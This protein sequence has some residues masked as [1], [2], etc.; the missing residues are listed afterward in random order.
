MSLSL[1]HELDARERGF[2]RWIRTNRGH[3]IP[4]APAASCVQR[5]DDVEADSRNGIRV[6]RTHSGRRSNGS[7]TCQ[8]SLRSVPRSISRAPGAETLPLGVPPIQVSG[9]AVFGEAST[10]RLGHLEAPLN[11]W[12]AS[13][14]RGRLDNTQARPPGSSIEP[15]SRHRALRGNH[16]S[17]TLPPLLPSQDEW[18]YVMTS[19]RLHAWQRRPTGGRRQVCTG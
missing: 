11:R 18:L 16:P 1:E 13:R 12:A 2:H 5:T 17:P 4:H 10:R 8:G 9:R 15:V 7:Q 14:V 3:V 6:A 19:D